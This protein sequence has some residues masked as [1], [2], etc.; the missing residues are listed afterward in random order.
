MKRVFLCLFFLLFACGKKEWPQ[1]I[2]SE[3]M[4][5]INHLEARLDQGCLL[6]NA[7]LGGRLVNLEYF[8]VEV[9]QDGCPTCPFTPSWTQK[10]YPFSSGVYRRENSY[11]FTI[12]EPLP[13]KTLR[14]RLKADNTQ[15]IIAPAVS[16]IITLGPPAQ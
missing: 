5:Q 16:E 10:F 14:I 6:V 3:E 7:K 15:H 13:A 4:I 1:P 9:E 11:I 12:C 2:A 8:L